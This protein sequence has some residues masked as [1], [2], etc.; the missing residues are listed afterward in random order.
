MQVPVNLRPLYNSKSMRN[1]FLTVEPSIDPR[2]GS[3]SF[4]EILNIVHHFMRVEVN[5]KYINQQISRNI[6]GEINPITRIFP[7]WLKNIVLS[8]VYSVKGENLTSGG[9]SNLGLVKLPDSMKNLIDEFL[10]VPPP[11]TG[12]KVKCGI[13]SYNDYA[14]ISFGSLVKE[15][16][17]EM[18]FFR[19]LRK[20][21]VKSFIVSN[22]EN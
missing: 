4:D 1:F 9:L 21:G 14:Y 2:L 19:A 7:L 22:K 20:M 15:K 5:Q 8:I 18:H 13:I 10:F 12:M 11:S 6:K 16:D 17:L 3:Y